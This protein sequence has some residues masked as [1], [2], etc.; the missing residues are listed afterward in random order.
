MEIIYSKDA[1][2]FLKKQ[3]RQTQSRIISAIEKIPNGDIRK[4]KGR[5]GYRLRVGTFRILFDEKG[6]IIN[7]IDIDN[8]GQIYK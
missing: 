3:T 6:T 4:L 7:I 1:I 2:K 8:R 5:S